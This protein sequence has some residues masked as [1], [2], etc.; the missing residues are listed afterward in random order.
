MLNIQSGQ[1]KITDLERIA[2]TLGIKER[3]DN[4]CLLIQDRINSMKEN[5]KTKESQIK[6][7]R[8]TN[9]TLSYKYNKMELEKQNKANKGNIDD[10]VS[11]TYR[12]ENVRLRKNNEELNQS[13]YGLQQELEKYR[14][15]RIN[16]IVYS[17]DI[18]DL[19]FKEYLL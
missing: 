11:D 4:L 15:D 9:E 18:K 12:K 7:L 5:I 1:G 3:S 17:K 8:M 19:E 16:K 6:R 10:S 13:I 2:T 14:N